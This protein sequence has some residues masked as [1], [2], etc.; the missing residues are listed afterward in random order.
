MDVNLRL[1]D[2]YNTV[3]RKKALHNDREK[4]AY[5]EAHISRSNSDSASNV[6]ENEGEQLSHCCLGRR[7][8]YSFNRD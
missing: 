2:D 6:S 4:L 7:T 3:R 1:F 5:P 8:S